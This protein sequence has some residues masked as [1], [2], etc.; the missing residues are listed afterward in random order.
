MGFA[1]AA[2]ALVIGLAWFAWTIPPFASLP[3][4][5]PTLALVPIGFA[6]NEIAYTL[7]GYLADSYLLYSASA[8]SGLAFVRAI[9]SGVMPLIAH[10]MYTDLE[11]NIATSVLVGVSAAFCIAPWVFFRWSK[12]LRARSPFAKFSLE[13]D[14]RTKVEVDKGFDSEEE[15]AI[16]SEKKDM[17]DSV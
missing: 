3:W 5:V 15:L 1:F 13:M 6:V 12:G 14:R 7:S 8:F 2:P 10:V 16:G 9:I 17:V 11:A 4:L